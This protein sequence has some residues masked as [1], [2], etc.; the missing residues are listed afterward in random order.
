MSDINDLLA[1][2]AKSINWEDIG[3]DAVVKGQVIDA[4]TQQCNVFKSTELAF[5]DDGSPQMQG[6]FTL[7]TDIR[8]P[9]V[10]NDDGIRRLHTGPYRKPGTI[11]YELRKKLQEKQIQRVEVGGTFACVWVAGIGKSGDPRQFAVDYAAPTGG[12][13]LAAQ[14][15]ATPTAATAAQPAPAAAPVAQPQPAVTGSLI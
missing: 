14:P 4:V 1:G 15:Q 5:W 6:V 9:E 2:G 3:R 7:Q 12:D 8:D 13:L 11:L 10:E